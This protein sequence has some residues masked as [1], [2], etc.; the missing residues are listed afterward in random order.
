MWILSAIQVN[1]GRK[2]CTSSTFYSLPHLLAHQIA[3]HMAS[4]ADRIPTAAAEA[5][6]RM[7]DIQSKIRNTPNATQMIAMLWSQLELLR[8]RFDRFKEIKEEQWN[9][10]EKP[11]S[12]HTLAV[13]NEITAVC[14]DMDKAIWTKKEDGQ[15]LLKIRVLTSAWKQRR[16]LGHHG[17]LG[18]WQNSLDLINSMARS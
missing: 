16:L 1:S 14:N 9:N 4:T 8:M 13:L 3:I 10:I 7:G 6:Q 5:L 18:S 17:A 2:I 12:V 11:L 15:Q